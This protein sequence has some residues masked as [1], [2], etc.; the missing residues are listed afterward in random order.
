M[1][2]EAP[3][4]GLVVPAMFAI[5]AFAVLIALGTWQVER[6]AWKEALI[7][8][9]TQRLEARPMALPPK[10]QW[11]NLDQNSDEFRRV[12]FRVEFIHSQEALVYTAGSALRPDITGPGYWVF[13]PARLTDG[14]VVVVNRGFVPADRIDT[15]T[16]GEGQILNPVE[17]VG[18]LRWP[19]V[20]SIFTPKDDPAGNVWYVRDHLAIAAAKHWGEVAPFFIDLEAPLPP[21]GLPRAGPLTV[22]LRNEHLQYAIT[23]FGLAGVLAVVFLLWVRGR[24]RQGAR[25]P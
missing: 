16:R 23:W 18:A 24:L 8:T 1:N 17:I 20:R 21:G 14:S 3:R 5:A 9:L 13:T 12:W 7:D 15:H 4:R 2:A 19:E 22:Q 10:E 25:E 11:A 6:K